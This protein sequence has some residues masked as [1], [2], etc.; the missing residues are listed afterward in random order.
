VNFVNFGHPD[1]RF[2]RST[3][4][5]KVSDEAHVVPAVDRPP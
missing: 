5:M 3:R 2:T 1:T 4:K